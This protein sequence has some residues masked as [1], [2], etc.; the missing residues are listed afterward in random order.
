MMM[1]KIN[2]RMYE[3][4]EL[5]SDDYNREITDVVTSEAEDD[6]SW[7]EESL[8]NANFDFLFEEDYEDDDV[9]VESKPKTKRDE[10]IESLSYLKSK[11]FKTKQD[12]E[13][14]YTLEMVL[15][16]MR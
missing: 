9:I 4:F 16:S 6:F 1:K 2:D 14:I 5:G 13:S 10:V 8:N 7:L 11:E 12:R 15:K 3:F